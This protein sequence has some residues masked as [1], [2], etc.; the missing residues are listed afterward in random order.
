MSSIL[1][2]LGILKPAPEDPWKAESDVILSNLLKGQQESNP[3]LIIAQQTN[4]LK[5]TTTSGLND[6]HCQSVKDCV[7]KLEA[8]PEV[9]IQRAVHIQST[10]PV[11][12]SQKFNSVQVQPTELT[13]NE[14]QEQQLDSMSLAL[15]R[16][17]DIAE[18]TNKELKT[19]QVLVSELDTDIDAASDTLKHLLNK[20][21]G[22]QRSFQKNSRMWII[23]GLC[24]LSVSLLI[25]IV[26]T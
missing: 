4:I 8:T 23:L 16:L 2:K 11:N 25:A 14:Q 17:Q 7:R 9:H 24:I 19:Q 26:Y 13:I 12:K 18:D 21:Q 22:L 20:L 3:S 10:L 6:E 15:S 1:R 5:L